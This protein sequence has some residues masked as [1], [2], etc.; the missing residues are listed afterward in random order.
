MHMKIK[1]VIAREKIFLENTR[2]WKSAFL[3]MVMLRKLEKRKISWDYA[4]SELGVQKPGDYDELLCCLDQPDIKQSQKKVLLALAMCLGFKNHILSIYF[5]VSTRYL[6]RIMLERKRDN[7]SFITGQKYRDRISRHLRADVQSVVSKTLHEPPSVYGINRTTWT[8]NLLTSTINQ[9]SSGLDF[10]VTRS[11]VSHAIRAMGYRFKKTR[12]VLTSNDP[13]YKEKLAKITRTLQRLGP[14][15][16]FFSIDEYGPISVRHRGGKLLTPNG[17]R[18]VVQQYQ[19][20]KG[21]IIM[22]AALELVNNQVSYFYSQKKDS[23]EMVKLADFLQKKY[24]HC[25]FLYFSW[26]AASWHSSRYFLSELK[27]L[28]DPVYRNENQ[29]PKI[30]LRPLPARAQ[31][32]N[33]IESVFSGMSRAV[34]QNSNYSSTKE[35]KEAIDAYFSE[36]NDFFRRYPHRA[37]NKIWG[38]ERVKPSFSVSNNCKDTFVKYRH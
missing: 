28:N 6:R 9:G 30:I 5:D 2:L 21:K 16:R 36:R 18:P 31:F 23:E 11:N 10:K 12:E 17:V 34:I 15:D 4:F 14:A 1:E 13:N 29:L 20:S 38:K 3:Q 33:V 8:I 22:T 26:D 37:G 25:R 19:E 27:K 32:L 24:H 35:M 7:F